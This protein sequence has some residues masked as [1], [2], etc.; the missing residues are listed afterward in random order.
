[1]LNIYLKVDTKSVL[2][3]RVTYYQG[4]FMYIRYTQDMQNEEYL[5]SRIM[6]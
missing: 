1:M 6:Y 3:I 2:T 4:W 5:L